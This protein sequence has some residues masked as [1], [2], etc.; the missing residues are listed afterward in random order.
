MSWSGEGGGR[1]KRGQWRQTAGSGGRALLSESSLPST[2]L[3]CALWLP[4]ARP[5]T[6]QRGPALAVAPYPVFLCNSA[7]KLRQEGLLAAGLG[8]EAKPCSGRG[9]RRCPLLSARCAPVWPPWGAEV[10]GCV[11]AH[12]SQQGLPKPQA[13]IRAQSEPV[14]PA[15]GWA[16]RCEGGASGSGLALLSAALPSPSPLAPLRSTR[17][18]RGRGPREAV[19]PLCPAVQGGLPPGRPL[20]RRGR[21]GACGPGTLKGPS[22]HTDLCVCSVQVLPPLPAPHTLAL[23]L[24]LPPPPTLSSLPADFTQPAF[25]LSTASNRFPQKPRPV[26]CLTSQSHLQQM[27]IEQL[28]HA[29]HWAQ[30]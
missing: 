29:R 2:S 25:P 22:S 18:I 10:E 1:T 26:P 19:V 12:A 21:G 20:P 11:T 5:M 7:R 28:L 27:F 30:Q 6:S 24:Q 17:L 3:S 9:L 23:S 8:P 13:Q 14:L 4:C 16:W 15:G